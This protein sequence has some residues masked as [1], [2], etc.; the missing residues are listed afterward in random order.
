MIDNKETQ[1]NYCVSLLRKTKKEHYANLNV[2]DICDNLK[3]WN[4][5]KPLLSEKNVKSEKIILAEGEEILN[6]NS[7]IAECL[8][9]NFFS[10]K[11]T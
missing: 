10:N 2:K 5:V 3:F 9:F 8:F 4:I 7:K 11:N 6:N 1:R